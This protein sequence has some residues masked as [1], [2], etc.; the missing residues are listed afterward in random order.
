MNLH[1][2]IK[3]FRL[4][5]LFFILLNFMQQIFN[6]FIYMIIVESSSTNNFFE[7]FYFVE[8]DN[9]IN[10]DTKI[11]FKKELNLVIANYIII[12]K[13][14]N[15]L[16]VQWD[17]NNYENYVLWSIIHDEFE[18]WIAIHF[19]QL[20]LKI[21]NDLRNFC[22]VHDVWINHNFKFDRIKIS[23]MLNIIRF[24]WDEKRT[25]IQIK[26]IENRFKTLFRVIKKRKHEFD[27]IFN[28]DDATTY[29]HESILELNR[30]I[31]N[32]IFDDRHMRFV[33]FDDQHDVYSM[34]FV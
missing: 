26:W 5:S 8:N 4:N 11:L 24:D 25:S 18:N 13:F 9:R 32:I 1:W 3:F 20:N 31:T 27:D 22:Y 12:N 34:L 14:V 30:N 28:F 2:S 17:N 19:D 10:V 16:L 15:Y 29:D 23:I 21:W 6:L 33:T 7:I